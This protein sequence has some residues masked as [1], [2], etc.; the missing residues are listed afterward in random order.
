[1]AI[2]ETTKKSPESLAHRAVQDLALEAENSVEQMLRLVDRLHRAERK[3]PELVPSAA[4]TNSNGD[5]QNDVLP[6][7]QNHSTR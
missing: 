3:T 4:G 7:L 5:F 1:M 6:L 2:D